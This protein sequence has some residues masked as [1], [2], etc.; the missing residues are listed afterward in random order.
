M[1]SFISTVQSAKARSLLSYYQIGGGTAGDF[2][3]G[4]RNDIKYKS[5]VTFEIQELMQYGKNIVV[6]VLLF[7]FR[8][9]EKRLTGRPTLLI[10]DEAWL[11][12]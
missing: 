1:T 10:I 3:D 2:L 8:Q 4:A 5:L 12:L 9:I 11:A 7:L 6:P